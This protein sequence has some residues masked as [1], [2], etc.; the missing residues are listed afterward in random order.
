[1]AQTETEEGVYVFCSQFC[2]TRFHPAAHSHTGSIERIKSELLGAYNDSFGWIIDMSR[3][4][5]VPKSL[6]SQVH[7]EIEI[8]TSVAVVSPVDAK[9]EDT[10]QSFHLPFR[11]SFRK[12]V[13]AV[14]WTLSVQQEI[15]RDTTLKRELLGFSWVSPSI[16]A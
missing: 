4:Q 16:Y 14:S 10:H 5:R 9:L 2:R 8:L 13:D 1:M 11:K 15:Q 6:I 7:Q 3:G 12:L